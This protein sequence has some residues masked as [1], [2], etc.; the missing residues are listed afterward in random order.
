MINRIFIFALLIF[1]ALGCS[2]DAHMI[3]QSNA[4][5]KFYGGFNVNLS[6]HL[7]LNKNGGYGLVGTYGTVENKNQIYILNTD[8]NGITQWQKLIGGKGND[9]GKD[10][11]VDND[12]NFV[13]L[14]DSSY[15]SVIDSTVFYLIKISPQGNVLWSKAYGLNTRIQQSQSLLIVSDG[16]IM[17]GHSLVGSNQEIL[18]I[19]TDFNGKFLWQKFYDVKSLP[20]VITSIQA[21]ADNNFIWSG[22]EDRYRGPGPIPANVFFNARVT[23]TNQAGDILF[24]RTYLSLTSQSYGDNIANEIKIINGGYIIIGTAS[25]SSGA[26]TENK[27]IFVLSIFNDGSVNWNKTYGSSTSNDYGQSI[28]LTNDGGF[29]I[30]GSTNTTNNKY[31]VYLDKIDGSGNPLWNIPK[32]FGGINDDFGQSVLQSQDGGVVVLATINYS[33]IPVLSLIKTNSLGELK[34]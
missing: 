17:M 13:V 6:S 26:P 12:G 34:K 32:T 27:D 2:K 3:G 23:N 7:A 22:G 16:Y 18:L 30:C 11:K 20:D 31:D 15:N 29:L 5:I 8:E 28:A 4:F 33:N 25:V 19:K 21:T 10:L 9:A 1:F 14:A 24:D